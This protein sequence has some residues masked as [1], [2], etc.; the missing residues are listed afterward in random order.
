MET[1]V[2]PMISK[3]EHVAELSEDLGEA[4]G[5]STAIASEPKDPKLSSTELSGSQTVK[6]VRQ[7]AQGREIEAT[8]QSENFNDPPVPLHNQ[9]GSAPI[10]SRLKATPMIA[11]K[12]KRKPANPIDELFHGLD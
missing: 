3:Y 2:V 8:G 1:E 9:D 6:D 10:V 5:R 4:V 11:K 12:Q 7:P